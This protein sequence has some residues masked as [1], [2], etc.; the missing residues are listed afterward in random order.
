M[1][2]A[3]DEGGGAFGAGAGGAV[4]PV[5]V[6]EGL[7]VQEFGAEDAR[8]DGEGGGGRRAVGEG[9]GEQLVV[10]A[11][12]CAWRDGVGRGVC[13]GGPVGR[14]KGPVVCGVG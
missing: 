1:V 10:V 5:G 8:I 6:R 14:G 4:V 13:V 7:E 3:V 9:G 11:R 2:G 12:G